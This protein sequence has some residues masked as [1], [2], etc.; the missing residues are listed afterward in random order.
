MHIVVLLSVDHILLY[1]VP[2]L[3]KSS[4]Y[5]SNSTCP[6]SPP[7]SSVYFQNCIDL[8]SLE[9]VNRIDGIIQINNLFLLYSNH[10]LIQYSLVPI[11]PNNQWCKKKPVKCFS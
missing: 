2:C 10:Y 5:K 3:V 7:L 1:Q 9:I 11:H 8:Q 6:S 4:F